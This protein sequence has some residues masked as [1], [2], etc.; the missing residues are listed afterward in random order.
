MKQWTTYGDSFSSDSRLLIADCSLGDK[1]L[2]KSSYSNFTFEADITLTGDSG[3]AGLIFRV[4]NPSDGPDAYKGYY[5]G[6][7]TENNVVL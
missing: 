2:L 5:A 3:N 6:I 4:P 1:A 7:S